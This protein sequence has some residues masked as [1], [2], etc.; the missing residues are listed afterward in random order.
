MGSDYYQTI[1]DMQKDTAAGMPRIG[2][3][4]NTVIRRAIIDKNARIGAGVRL[5]NE[6]GVEEAD[7]PD[8]SYFI[9]DRIILVSKNAVIKD[10]TVV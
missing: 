7:A 1:E 8:K 9:R 10:G 6:A 2:I 3:G 4:E 5:L